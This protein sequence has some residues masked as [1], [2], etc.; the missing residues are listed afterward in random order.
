MRFISKSEKISKT[1]IC[2]VKKIDFKT[3]LAKNFASKYP[4]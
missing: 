2:N 3:P 4:L 1:G